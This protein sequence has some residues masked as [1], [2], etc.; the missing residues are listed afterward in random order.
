MI[1]EGRATVEVVRGKVAGRASASPWR[2]NTME[3]DDFVEAG[4]SS[5]D[6]IGFVSGF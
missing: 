2:Q 3:I 6:R 4:F 5:I 1:S